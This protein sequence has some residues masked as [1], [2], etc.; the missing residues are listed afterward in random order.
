MVDMGRPLDL[1]DPGAE[2]LLRGIQGNIIKGHGRDHSAHLLLTMTGPADVVRAWI[3]DFASRRVTTA[4]D[5]RQGAVAFRAGGG[6]GATFGMFLLAPDGYRHLGITDDQF[7]Q[8][9]DPINRARA[10]AEFVRG[11]KGPAPDVPSGLGNDPPS[12]QWEAPYQN[13]VHAMAL[14]AD[15]DPSRLEAVV[16]EVT[17]SF[18]GVFDLLTVERGA[19][20]TASFGARQEVTIEHF[21]FE[22]GISQPV[23]V[24]QDLD[25][26]LAARGGTR[27]NPGAPLS[28]AL[29]RERADAENY[30]SFVVFRKLEQ[31]VKAF[32][33]AVDALRPRLG[34]TGPDLSRD[35]V[36][37]LAVGRYRSGL[38]L[39]PGPSVHRG[40]G[41]NDFDY[42][43]D[44]GGQI[45]P[46]Q[47]HIRKTNP[48]GDLGRLPGATRAARAQLE[49][50]RRIVRRGITYGTR[51]DL[52]DP[53]ALGTPPSDGVGLLF[54]CFQSTLDQFVI[55]Q[56]G[57]D[58]NDFVVPNVGVD[59][60]IGSHPAPLPQT[61]PGGGG[62]TFTMANFVNLRGGEYFFAPSM[63]FLR[64]ESA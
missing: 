22:D 15:D 54:V 51:P 46:F 59:A 33:D 14:L 20:L 49:R 45:C 57:S 5:A 44:P 43:V 32:W 62:R 36:G 42:E 16:A 31:N 7:P 24:Q 4:H 25:A 52:A 30:G 63:A 6:A 50:D 41:Q 47:A 1:D 3:A 48:R 60:V 2:D 8:P 35:D 29:T 23:L 61:W 38:P 10:V 12:G 37:A 53:A 19:R 34:V 27:Y 9:G 26:E 64:G 56:D 39:V 40:A 18:A 55:Q 21:G 58:S 11:M 17:A 13:S 28:L